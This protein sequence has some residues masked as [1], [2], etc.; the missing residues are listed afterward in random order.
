[1]GKPLT[2]K[3]IE[4]L[5]EAGYRLFEGENGVKR[6]YHPFLF[7]VSIDA[8]TGTLAF[9]RTKDDF[10]NGVETTALIT[11]AETFLKAATVLVANA[12]E[13]DS[14]SPESTNE[15]AKRKEPAEEIADLITEAAATEEEKTEPKF[16]DGEP[17]PKVPGIRGAAIVSVC[18]GTIRFNQKATELVARLINEGKNHI[19]VSKD[20]IA[21][22]LFFQEN[23]TSQS[24]LVKEVK[25]D[26]TGKKSLAAA[27]MDVVRH[28]F[29]ECEKTEQY[30]AELLPDRQSLKLT[31]YYSPVADRIIR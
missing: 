12:Y 16:R 9:Q 24:I 8:N 25:S 27:R 3:Q 18:N 22:Y 31:R 11:L 4:R 10:I 15:S 13:E 1:M 21:T 14:T 30:D 26:K 29:G 2:D 7:R 17:E 20:S 5:Q 23:P 6:L 28:Y 19:I